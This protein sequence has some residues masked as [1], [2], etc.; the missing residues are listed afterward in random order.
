MKALIFSYILCV[1]FM[2]AVATVVC[3]DLVIQHRFVTAGA[4][5]FLVPLARYF[6]DQYIKRTLAQ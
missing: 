6:L 5:A 3:V 1:L 2:S 4:V